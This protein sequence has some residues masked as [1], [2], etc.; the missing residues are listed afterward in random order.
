MKDG[1][2]GHTKCLVEHPHPECIALCQVVVN[3]HNM[4]SFAKKRIEVYRH[5]ADERL[6][7]SRLHLSDVSLME[8]DSTENLHIV[9][10]HVP[11]EFLFPQIH[12]L[13]LNEF[14]GANNQSKCLDEQVF[15]SFPL[16][17]SFLKHCR[18]IRELLEREC[19]HTIR[20]R[21]LAYFVHSRPESFEFTLIGVSQKFVEEIDDGHVLQRRAERGREMS[22]CPSLPYQG[23]S[24]FFSPLSPLRKPGSTAVS[25]WSSASFR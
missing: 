5:C 18:F 9:R 1:S 22:N 23:T 19:L 10:N 12:G 8:D 6:S 14:T 4:H 15:H 13:P 17:Q 16:L 21:D 2:N 24:D 20:L 7:F 11:N 25:G 3:G